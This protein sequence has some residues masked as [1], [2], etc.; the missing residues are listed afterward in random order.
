[1]TSPST[2]D[3]D[4]KEK[5]AL[6][7]D[8]LKVREYFLFDPKA[9][10]LEPP[11]QGYRLVDGE[12][13]PIPSVAGRLPSEVMGAPDRGREARRGE[14]FLRVFNPATVRWLPLPR[15]FAEELEQVRPQS[16]SG[17][18]QHPAEGRRIG[19]DMLPAEGRRVPSRNSSRTKMIQALAEAEAE[20]QRLRAELDSLRRTS[21]PDGPDRHVTEV[22]VRASGCGRTDLVRPL[23]VGAESALTRSRLASPLASNWSRRAAIATGTIEL[24]AA[25]SAMP[26]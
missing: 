23:V 17:T 3:E 11:L 13:V 7:R 12:Y 5:F 21:P 14:S 25:A 16:R 8:V 4:L 2:R 20:R 24:P 19:E 9:E 15:S 18:P 22:K 26:A 6:Y 1:M 10:Y